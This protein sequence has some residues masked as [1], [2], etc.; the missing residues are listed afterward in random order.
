MNWILDVGTVFKNKSNG[1]K[2]EKATVSTVK[3]I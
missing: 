1:E 2:L 3:M